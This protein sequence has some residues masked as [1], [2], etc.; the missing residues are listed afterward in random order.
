MLPR[1]Q[2]NVFM[3]KPINNLTDKPTDQPRLGWLQIIQWGLLVIGCIVGF[4][5]AV[6][7]LLPQHHDKFE[8]GWALFITGVIGILSFIVIGIIRKRVFEHFHEIDELKSEIQKLKDI[9]A[10]K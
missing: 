10:Q 5:G 7:I 1:I 6:F 4:F 2:L 3:D 8:A 9:L